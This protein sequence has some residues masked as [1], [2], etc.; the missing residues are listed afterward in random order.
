MGEGRKILGH[1]HHAPTRHGRLTTIWRIIDYRGA[2]FTIYLRQIVAGIDPKGIIPSDTASPVV[3]N[4]V[5]PFYG[6]TAVRV[7]H[8]LGITA[9]QTAKLFE[10]LGLSRCHELLITQLRGSVQRCQRTA[11]VKSRKIRLA[12]SGSFNL[13]KG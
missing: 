12:C 13:S 2:D 4:A 10:F 6:G 9:Q 3:L 11:I 5:A 8:I 7:A 1:L